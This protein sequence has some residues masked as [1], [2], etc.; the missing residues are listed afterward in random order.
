MYD[1]LRSLM[2]RVFTI[3][4]MV[5]EGKFIIITSRD[6]YVLKLVELQLK[7]SLTK[8]RFPKT[9]NNFRSKLLSPL[10]HQVTINDGGQVDLHKWRYHPDVLQP[11]QLRN[12]EKQNSLP[13]ASKYLVNNEKLK[14]QTQVNLLRQRKLKKKSSEPKLQLSPWKQS[15][16]QICKKLVVIRHIYN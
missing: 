2:P 7:E 12:Y 11:P 14:S 9:T 10:P 4:I 6:Q 16:F 8:M 3:I 13:D 15:L 1:K 5:L